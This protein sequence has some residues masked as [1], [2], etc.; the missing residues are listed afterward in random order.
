M[1]SDSEE[2]S[3]LKQKI[4]AI[5]SKYHTPI[6][7]IGL[8]VSV[9]IFY[10]FGLTVHEYWHLRIADCFG[11]GGFIDFTWF[12]GVYMPHTIP[13]EPAWFLIK[14]AGGLGTAFVM[15]LLWAYARWTYSKWDLNIEFA[16]A[17]IG[18]IHLFYG[19]VE[20]I[21]LESRY[22]AII[23]AIA[24]IAACIIVVVI[25]MGEIIEYVRHDNM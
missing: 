14:L 11:V 20:G 10:I 18:A 17:L 13:P 1:T 5:G 22:F 15:S 12:G 3:T 7:L 21:L 25:Y 2:S 4:N 16:A 23:A 9:F 19:I 6:T 8:L 24:V